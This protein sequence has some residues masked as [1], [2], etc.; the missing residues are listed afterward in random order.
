MTNPLAF[1][2]AAALTAALAVPALAQARP[3]LRTMTC[4]QAQ[5]LVKQRG[6]VVMTTG[7]H[8]YF[9]FVSRI[10]Y[11]D[12]WEQLFVKYGSTRD[13]PKCPV[14]YECKEPLFNTFNR[15]D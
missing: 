13:N 7:P 12:S 8:T 9:R 4:A 1:L 15:F 6:Q 2:L 14:A 10:N 5:A 3:D 11:C